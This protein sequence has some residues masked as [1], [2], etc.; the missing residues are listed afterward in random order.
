[1]ATEA[2]ATSEA[3]SSLP[4]SPSSIEHEIEVA[5]GGEGGDAPALTPGKLILPAHNPQRLIRRL[6]RYRHSGRA[7]F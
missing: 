4:E 5:I 1:M 2:S 6:Q 7:G 3:A